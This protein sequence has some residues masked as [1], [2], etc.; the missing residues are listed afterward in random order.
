MPGSGPDRELEYA[1]VVLNGFRHSAP[2]VVFSWGQYQGDSQLLL[3][4]LL[5]DLPDTE[6]ATTSLNVES[7]EQRVYLHRNLISSEP[8]DA[9]GVPLEASRSKGGSGLIKSQS[10]CPFK[11][12]A[13]YR[14]GIKPADELQDGVKASDRG[15]LVHRVLETFWRQMERFSELE[16]LLQQ[17]D[18]LN[19]C[20]NDILDRELLRFKEEVY[21]QPD[22]LYELERQRAF[23]AVRRWLLEAEQGRT[24]FIIDKVEKRQSIQL[25]GLELSVTADR[26]DQ[27]ED[28]S[29][30]IIDYKTGLKKTASL[31][32]ERP[33]EPQLPLYALLDEESTKG[34]CFGVV[35]PDKSEWQGLLDSDAAFTEGKCRTM[36]VPDEGWQQQMNSWRT[37]LEA[38]AQEYI[39]G[40]ARVAPL[41]PTT[42]QYCH[43]GPLCRIK[44][45]HRD[46]E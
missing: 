6:A 2:N 26:I 33:E 21:L 12:Y 41:N 11:A 10:L 39:Q 9:V 32:G 42:C 23:K 3:S 13:E 1:R 43:L 34:I 27:L 38:L 31:I 35:R 4:P 15:T 46:S 17:E 37:A 25:A 40:V 36:M 7:R 44:E 24:R 8:A 18:A 14:L 45:H 16:R 20:L 5:E 30:I 28:G 19:T 22:A 29:R